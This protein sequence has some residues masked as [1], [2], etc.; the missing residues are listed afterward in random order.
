M[1][2]ETEIMESSDIV[3][4]LNRRTKLFWEGKTSADNNQQR[5]A[6]RIYLEDG[7]CAGDT[8]SQ[9][10]LLEQELAYA[11]QNNKL[12]HNIHEDVTL[13][14]LVGEAFEP[15]LQSIYVFAP[16]RLVP[17]VNTYY[18]DVTDTES[19]E[20]HWKKFYKLL[21]KLPE[22]KR[23]RIKNL[24]TIQQ[25]TP[26]ED[27]PTKVFAYL[28]DALQ[29]DLKDVQ[30][31]VIIDITGAKKTMVAGALMLAAY[32]Q[33]TINYI[34]TERQSDEHQPLGYTCRFRTIVSPIDD[35]SLHIWDQVK[36]RYSAY[37][38]AGA[39]Q[40][41]NAIPAKD[42]ID[43][44]TH[45]DLHLFL[46]VCEQWDQGQL[47]QA[48]EKAATLPES[49]QLILPTTVNALGVYWPKKTDTQLST[50]LF[51]HPEAIILYARDE[52]AR[53]Q[54]LMGK[55]DEETAVRPAMRSAFA[56]AYALLE[57]LL[58]ARLVALHCA[59]Q[60]TL[61]S[62]GTK[63]NINLTDTLNDKID[64]EM[65]QL[66]VK[67]QTKDM[68]SLLG[69]PSANTTHNKNVYLK[70]SGGRCQVLWHK[71]NNQPYLDEQFNMYST[72]NEALKIARNLSTHNY[73]P[74][75]PEKVK[76][77]LALAEKSLEDYINNWQSFITPEIRENQGISKQLFPF[78]CVERPE[79][80]DLKQACNLT[81]I[82]DNDKFK[83]VV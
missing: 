27:N 35:L 41:L 32:T 52:I 55:E 64:K 12:P 6:W 63:T 19:T 28:R 60:M 71:A 53:V 44:K 26:V 65:L 57:T 20:R 16:T 22:E 75:D 36:M 10:P 21:K 4:N 47:R 72:S 9:P 50:K 81:I 46:E 82:P 48:Q 29:E 38:F 30:K 17:I 2:Q 8:T 67:L 83:E 56:R 15:L 33:A 11:A 7:Q 51:C 73:F 62:T 1:N 61:Y 54:R 49:L 40:Q 74:V 70:M 76:M 59:K 79:W 25:I 31:Q 68:C 69:V 45:D 66:L 18:G 13:V 3:K 34:D 24:A 80:D 42:R 39:R 23:K 5:R 77:A 37:D 78:P 43:S 58:K 14:I